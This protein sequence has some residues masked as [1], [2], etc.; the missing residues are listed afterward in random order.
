MADGSGGRQERRA[1]GCGRGRGR[2]PRAP[3]GGWRRRRLRAASASPHTAAPPAPA[4]HPAPTPQFLPPLLVDSAIR[5]D[6]FMFSKVW[7]GARRAAGGQRPGCGRAGWEAGGQQDRGNGQLSPRQHRPPTQPPLPLRPPP[8]PPTHPPPSLLQLWVHI[9]SMAFVMVILSAIIL[10]PRERFRAAACPP[11]CACACGAR[12]GATQA[13]PAAARRWPRV[14]PAAAW[15]HPP[16]TR[17]LTRTPTLPQPPPPA[18]ILFVLGFASRGFSWVHGALFAA[19]IASTD[20]LAAT[21]ILKQGG[22]LA[23]VCQGAAVGGSA[24]GPPC[25]VARQPCQPAGAGLRRTSRSARRLHP[26]HPPRPH[27]TAGG[28][29][30]KLVVLMEGEALLNDASGACVCVCVCRV[31]GSCCCCLLVWAGRHCRLLSACAC[32]GVLL[33]AAAPAM[34]LLP[35]FHFAAPPGSHPLTHTTLHCPPWL[36]PPTPPRSHH[37][38]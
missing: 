11:A 5:I 23:D 4:L 1:A 28:G 15:L 16:P 26:P 14:A 34:P 31:G 9:L 24:P 6:F 10:T 29:P 27:P 3:S 20:A 22:A 7:C 19:M 12:L 21:A 35:S 2:I 25:A 18:V 33:P 38:V 37:A 36:H 8:H 32:L 17:T 13:C 30:E